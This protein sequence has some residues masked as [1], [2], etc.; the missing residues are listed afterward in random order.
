MLSLCSHMGADTGQTAYV[1]GLCCGAEAQAV[2][3]CRAKGTCVRAGVSKEHASCQHCDIAQ[4]PPTFPTIT[5]TAYQEIPFTG[6]S[7]EVGAYN[8]SLHGDDQR[9]FMFAWRSGWTGSDI[10]TA[11]LSDSYRVTGR[12]NPLPL[13]H[14]RAIR[15]REDPRLFRFRGEWHVSFTGYERGPQWIYSVM[16][17]RFNGGMVSSIWEPRY[18]HRTHEKNWTFFEHQ[19]ELHAVYRIGP[20]HKVF[21]FNGDCVAQVY[22]TTWEPKW[23]WGDMRGGASPQF[24]NGEWYNWFHG[25]AVRG[26]DIYYTLGLYTFE[27]KPPFRPLRMIRTPLVI[28]GVSQINGQSRKAIYYPCGAALKGGKWHISAGEHD[29]RC[30]VAA[31]D[32]NDIEGA[33]QPCT[34]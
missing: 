4:R 28:G 5:P 6:R 22:E 30:S 7:Q 21:R 17:A 33:L 2:F 1:E 9:G 12:M 31:F 3:S 8:C 11:R 24:C 19:N 26:R 13:M 14:P 15:G 34:T 18:D 10:Y 27:A 25:W 23:G 29:N 16:V 32:A 20:V